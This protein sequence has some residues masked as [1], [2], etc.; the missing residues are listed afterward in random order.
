MKMLL[1]ACLTC[2][3]IGVQVVGPLLLSAFVDDAQSDETLNVLFV[4]AF[5]F[6]AISF[7][8]M[9]LGAIEAYVSAD[10][11]MSS[12]NELRE[13]LTRRLLGL[14]GRFYDENTTGYLIERVDG[15]IGL[16]AN[17]FSEFTVQIVGNSLFLI[18]IIVVVLS[19]NLRLGLFVGLFDLIAILVLRRMRS[20]GVAEWKE[21]RQTNANLFGFIEERLLGLEDIGTNGGRAFVLGQLSSILNRL[22]HVTRRARRLSNVTFIAISSLFVFGEALALFLSISEYRHHLISIGTVFLLEYYLQ[23]VIVPIN[24]LVSQFQDFQAAS[25]SISRVEELRS[26]Q[27]DVANG[28]GVVF[29]DDAPKV[30]FSQVTFGYDPT[31][32]V[33]HDMTF[34]VPPGEVVGVLGPTGSGKTSLANLLVRLYDPQTGSVRIAGA[35]IRQAD[36]KQLRDY[37]GVVPQS[38][39]IFRGTVRDNVTLFRKDHD[40]AV[41]IDVLQECGLRQWLERLPNGLDTV[42]DAND[43][44]ISAGEAQLLSIARTM[45]RNPRVVILDEVSSRLDPL[46]EESI[47]CAIA[48][49]L[50]NRTAMIIAHRPRTI[51]HAHWIML[52]D[53]GGIREFGKR[54]D[55][56]GDPSSAFSSVWRLNGGEIT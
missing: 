37:V 14:G 52:L 35:D 16:L 32:P 11:A 31:Q 49:L 12:T 42:L 10:I 40:D 25:A 18:G 30:E 39:H 43:S 46:T 54:A 51:M 27:S 19:M 4:I 38:V 22:L 1:L 17:F 29:G 3:S 24:A 55:L 47:Q 48:R 5:A 8:Q 56:Q 44:G 53:G 28:P 6:I 20:L 45:I 50:A 9:L 36:L 34:S 41:L 21:A 7:L 23:L 33:L 13:D 26:L 15:D 2:S